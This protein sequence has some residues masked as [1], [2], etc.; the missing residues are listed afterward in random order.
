VPL[1]V[2]VGWIQVESGGRLAETTS[3]D[4]RGYF[5][6]LPAESHDLGLDH[7]KLS[8]DSDYSLQ[9]GFM[10]IAYY[11]HA[12]QKICDADDLT[13]VLPMTEYYWRMVKFGHCMGLGSVRVFL[14]DAAAAGA[15]NDWPS[16]C[17][18]LTANDARYLHQIKHSP[19]KW[20]G[21]INRMFVIGQPYGID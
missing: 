10:L 15:A 14:R 19:V 17:A 13:C 11:Q 6:L 7:S 5:Q 2:A 12:L 21:L 20:I 9:A 3:L 1:G 16:L 8:S 4:E 18:Y